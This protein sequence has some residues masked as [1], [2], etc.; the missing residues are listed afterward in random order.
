MFIVMDS[1]N[2]NIR[3]LIDRLERNHARAIAQLRALASVEPP[4]F[5]DDRHLPRDLISL[6]EAAQIAHRKPD[7]VRSWARA[8]PHYR[9]GGIAW[10]LRGRWYVSRALF[11]VFLLQQENSN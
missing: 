3:Q 4:H 7:T 10:K 9:P 2:A 5:D 1:P 11:R 8:N 6:S